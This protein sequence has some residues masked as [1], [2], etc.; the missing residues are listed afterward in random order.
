MGKTNRKKDEYVLGH[1][2]TEL[3]RLEKQAGFYRELTRNMLVCAGIGKGMRVL[4]FGA[5]AGDVSLLIS[6]LVGKKGE[7]IAVDRAPEALERARYRMEARGVKNVT[8]VTG[9]EDTLE[10]VLGAGKVDAAVGRLVLLHQKDP[11][12]VFEKIIKQVR[13]GGIVAFQEIDGE[14]TV[15]TKPMLPLMTQ[16]YHWIE[17][18]LKAGG[19]PSDM[20]QK[21]MQAFDKAG[22]STRHIV[23]E[24]VIESGPEAMCYEYYADIIRTVLPIME[25]IK[26]ATTEEIQLETLAGRLRDE[27]VANQALFIPI[28]FVSAYGRLPG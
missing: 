20:S 15:W 8:V 11:V 16:T 19:M 4:D 12:A 5:G 18:T 25:K 2:A 26:I 27:A 10:E 28:F 24:G 17:Q 6:E 7:V 3:E 22:I 13:P 21:L 9:D 1:S 23:R 14:S